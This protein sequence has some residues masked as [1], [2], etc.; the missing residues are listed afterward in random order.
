[1][2]PFKL[3]P[4]C[5]K[6]Y[7]AILLN[8]LFSVKLKIIDLIFTEFI[9]NFISTLAPLKNGITYLYSNI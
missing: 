1:M 2:L 5:K 9:V 4:D 7:T 3:F 8:Q 6:I